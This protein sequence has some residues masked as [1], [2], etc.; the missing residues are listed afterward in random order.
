MV[1]KTEEQPE[2]SL[3]WADQIAGEIAT[4]KNF[5]YLDEPV[6]RLKKFVVKTSAS[7]SGVLH[8]GR[9]SDTIRGESV[10]RAL[11]DA[12]C[13][14]ELVWVAEDMDPMRKLPKGVPDNYAKYI[15]MPVTDIPDPHGCHDSY[16]AHHVA[17]YFKV[18]DE[19]V[20]TKMPKYSMR[21][22]YKNGGFRPFIS[23]IIENIDE[24][25]K[26]QNKYRMNPLP[27][28]WSPW[29][30]IC[31]NCGKI[32]TPKV[33]GFHDGAVSYVCSNYQFEK[34]KA[35]GCGH[36]GDADPLKDDGKLMW[37]SEWASQWARWGIV[38]EG[39]GKEYQVPN[40]AFWVN[41]EICERVLGFPAPV[42]IFYEHIMIDG[43]KMSASL[44]NVVYPKDWL[45]CAPAELL[46]FF[47]NKRLMKTRSFSWKDLPILFADYEKH[48]DVFFG[49][50][51]VGNEKESVHMK[52]LFEVSQ[53]GKPKPV[54]MT[55]EKAML[56][57]NTEPS[58]KGPMITY[59]RNWMEKHS[60][61]S[62]IALLDVP[63]K[64]ALPKG[65]KESLKALAKSLQNAGT[66]EEITDAVWAAA[67]ASGD[68]CEFFR[69]AYLALIG[70]EQGPRLGPFIAAAG[71][72]KVVALL[73]KV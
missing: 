50:L 54:G 13:K 72:K 46:R 9:L 41:A 34:S 53:M 61:E 3:F 37:K 25:R 8:I 60:P 70:R 63:A 45:E 52:R 36:K 30:P 22:E 2:H 55:F 24:I 67:K 19:F 15:G 33:T 58:S 21:E 56:V 14:A 38:S 5:R 40:S 42:P 4:R 47:Y 57:A 16:A 49:K 39:A 59:A 73:E 20:S 66:E 28:D 10:F 27:K 31:A 17:E 51:D 48:A 6:P 7:L 26:I 64:A 29:I 11:K 43:R 71:K 62:R 69:S 23:K 44:G 1:A 68:S 18:I 32:I 35:V 65:M 12:G